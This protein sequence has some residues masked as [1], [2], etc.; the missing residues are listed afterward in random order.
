[1]L[2]SNILENDFSSGYLILIDSFVPD[3]GLSQA[4]SNI[5][6]LREYAGFF[7]SSLVVSFNRHTPT[8]VW[9]IRTKYHKTVNEI[10]LCCHWFSTL[11]LNIQKDE[12]KK[13]KFINSK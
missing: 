7:C 4:T 6:S 10:C 3:F 12:N 8:V 9:L 11:V 13:Q 1:M 5:F 2:I